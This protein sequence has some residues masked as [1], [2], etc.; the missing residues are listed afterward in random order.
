MQRPHA[1]AALAT[2]AALLLFTLTACGDTADAADKQKPTA[3]G[4][5]TAQASSATSV[6]V[7]W[8]PAS[9][10]KAITGY[11]VYRKGVRVKSVTAA[12]QMI[13]IDGLTPS[14]AYTFTVRAR[15]AAGNLSGPSRAVVVTTPA[16][17]PADH[18]PPTRP[19][20]LRGKV[21]GSRAATLSWGGSTDDVGV[22]SY[23]IYQEDSRIHS[24][25]GTQTTARLTGLRPGTVYTFT[26]R[27]RDAADASSPDSDAFDLT[28][29]SA[30]GAPAGTAPT[31]L[32]ITIRAQGKEYAID[33]DWKQPDTGGEIPAYQ[34]FLDGRLT[35]TIVWGGK[36]PTGRASYRLTVGDPR[37]TRYS[38]KIRARLPD[39]K[40]G[41]FS[42]RRTIV[43]GD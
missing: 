17:T 25:P 5:V 15:D 10:N 23:D 39:G 3:P 24:V 22:T 42:A 31:D 40:W 11:Q 32:R 13:D 37:G 33:L 21:D 41:D 8:D 12:R 35:T 28:T 26:V 19:V 9:D 27:A 4:G 18:E 30:P 43:L 2:S 6:H 7:M 20:G 29:P 38:M 36:P 34:L 16:P 1:H 14:T